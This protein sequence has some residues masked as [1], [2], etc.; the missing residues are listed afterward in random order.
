MATNKKNAGRITI[1]NL[2]D[3]LN[4]SGFL[5]PQ[6][7][8]QLDRFNKLYADYD[9]KLKD[10]TIDAKAIIDGNSCC[11]LTKNKTIKFNTTYI[12]NEELKMVARKGQDIPQHIIDKMKQKHHKK[13]GEE[14]Q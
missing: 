2:D 9:F 8:L 7:E 14:Q 5:F 13:D 10:I 1:D 6:N 4:S 3:W 12:I 11:D